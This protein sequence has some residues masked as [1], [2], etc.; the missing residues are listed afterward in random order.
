MYHMIDKDNKLGNRPNAHAKMR[1]VRRRLH[2][3]N[4]HAPSF[5]KNIIATGEISNASVDWSVIPR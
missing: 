2:E 1:E 5:F 3:M 4:G